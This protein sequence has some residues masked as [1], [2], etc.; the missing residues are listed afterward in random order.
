MPGEGST[1]LLQ[2]DRRPKTNKTCPVENTEAPKQ[3]L[4]TQMAGGNTCFINY[5]KH[6]LPCHKAKVKLQ[7]ACVLIIQIISNHYL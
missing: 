1:G 3:K 2:V 7:F 6:N 4:I 5:F